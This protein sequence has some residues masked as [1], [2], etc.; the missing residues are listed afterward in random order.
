MTTFK[1]KKSVLP[2]ES[3]KNRNG[4]N[5]H[6]RMTFLS[7]LTDST[8]HPLQDLIYPL[9]YL[10]I[11]RPVNVHIDYFSTSENFNICFQEYT[12]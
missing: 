8:Y 3:T 2:S 12:V 9:R 1:K 10:L 4:S 6:N 5:S 7:M 11:S